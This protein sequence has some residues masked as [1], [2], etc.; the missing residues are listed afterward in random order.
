MARGTVLPP[1]RLLRVL[2]QR[3][4]V[5]EKQP[6]DRFHNGETLPIQQNLRLLLEPPFVTADKSEERIRSIP[7]F[8]GN[9]AQYHAQKLR[10]SIS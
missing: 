5:K 8:E 1:G 9:G 6:L 2:P 3:H 4:C 10:R 7:G